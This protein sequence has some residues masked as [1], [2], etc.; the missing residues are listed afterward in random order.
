MI[1]PMLTPCPFSC[2]GCRSEYR[3]FLPLFAHENFS[4][5]A[6]VQQSIAGR[7][8]G[9]IGISHDLHLP[10]H[11]R[12]LVF[13]DDRPARFADQ[14]RRSHLR[15]L[16]THITWSPRLPEIA[17]VTPRLAWKVIATTGR[18]VLMHRDL[19]RLR[20]LHQQHAS[21][22]PVC[23]DSGG[24]T[25]RAVLTSNPRRQTRTADATPLHLAGRLWRHARNP[26][27]VGSQRSF[28]SWASCSPTLTTGAFNR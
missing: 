5:W 7:Q 10:R 12:H 21:M 17:P 9:R 20:E 28:Q 11:S 18:L 25:N 26:M 1:F 24:T 6:I 3:A 4:A 2:F 14:E 8:F 15:A 22:L 19:Q 23:S 27:H 13:V 16:A